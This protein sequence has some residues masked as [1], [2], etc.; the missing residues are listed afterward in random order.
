LE[1]GVELPREDV[2]AR[3]QVHHFVLSVPVERR[4]AARLEEAAREVVREAFAAGGF[5]ALWAVHV[6]HG[7]RPHAHVLVQARGEWGQ[8]LATGPREM[9]VLRS[10]LA[11]AAGVVGIRVEAT[12]RADRPEV[13]AGILRGEA[14]LRLRAGRHDYRDGVEG[15]GREARE[16][17]RLAVR[18][19]GWLAGEHGQSFLRRLEG[20]EVR[21]EEGG[22][23]SRWRKRE[24]EAVGDHLASIAARLREKGVFVVGGEDATQEALR[25][26]EAMRREDDALARWYMCHRP[27]AFG[28]VG[29]GRGGV[30]LALR[31]LVR[32]LPKLP[33]SEG[34]EPFRAV[35]A[36]LP[37]AGVR[38]AGGARAIAADLAEVA[39]SRVALA[40]REESLGGEGGRRFGDA[41]ERAVALRDQAAQLL[42]EQITTAAAQRR[43]EMARRTADG[44]RGQGGDGG[45]RDPQPDRG[46]R[47]L[48]R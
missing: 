43:L 21:R 6:E 19:P 48:E 17:A 25:A 15:W 9:D 35:R 16:A 14:V 11:E 22:W 45:R 24:G 32:G 23:L 5:R 40:R 33:A 39:R 29:R 3:P 2:W 38:V 10:R 47:G 42:E 1:P 31:A 20:Q 27:A 18:V 46:G 8:A 41:L 36:S 12:R 13:V 37:Q 28:P 44:G 4:E 7:K 34:A 26:F 30:D